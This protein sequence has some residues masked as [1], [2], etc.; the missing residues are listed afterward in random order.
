MQYKTQP[1]LSKVGLARVHAAAID[2]CVF[3]V[4]DMVAWTFARLAPSSIST[5][6]IPYASSAQSIFYVSGSVTVQILMIGYAFMVAYGMGV[7]HRSVGLKMTSVTRTNSDSLGY[8]PVGAFRPLVRLVSLVFLES[9]V[10]IAFHLFV[11]PSLMIDSLALGAVILS[12]AL[13]GLDGSPTFWDKISGTTF[14]IEE[15]RTVVV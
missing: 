15:D 14:I 3:A 9:M 8:R 13:A 11:G 1:L 2:A 6:P 7:G 4:L 12:V 10:V 5:L